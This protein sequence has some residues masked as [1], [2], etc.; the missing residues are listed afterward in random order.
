MTTVQNIWIGEYQ[1]QFPICA[2]LPD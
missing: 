1:R 2:L